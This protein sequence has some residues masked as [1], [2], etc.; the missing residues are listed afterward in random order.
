MRVT[1][2]VHVRT[3]GDFFGELGLIDRSP[4]TATVT[5]VTDSQLLMLA[6]E[7][8]DKLMRAY[9]EMRVAIEMVAATHRLQKRS[10][11]APHAEIDRDH[12]S[13]KQY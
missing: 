11:S 12:H 1:G 10:S 6:E 4:R 8:F 13:N 2:S 9:P 5:A 7:D 3:T